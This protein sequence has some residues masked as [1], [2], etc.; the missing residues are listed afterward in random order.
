MTLLTVLMIFIGNI[1]GGKS[2][3]M[4]GLVVAAAMN[5]S[6]Y[7]FSDKIVLRMD[8]AKELTRNEA[9]ELLQVTEDLTRRGELPMPTLY[10]I[11]SIAATM[12]GAIGMIANMAQ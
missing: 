6:S 3:M 5:F 11:G 8:G 2:V 9:S 10:L 12:A 7:W 1:L 4:M